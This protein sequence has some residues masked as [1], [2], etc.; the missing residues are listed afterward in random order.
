MELLRGWPKGGE[1]RALTLRQIRAVLS[2]GGFR[3]L[4]GRPCMATPIPGWAGDCTTDDADVLR[5]W[6]L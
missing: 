6:R 2:C 3:P 4:Y 5:N 1:E